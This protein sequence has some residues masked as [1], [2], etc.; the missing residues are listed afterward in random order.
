MSASADCATVIVDQLLG[1]GVTEAVLAPGSRSAPLAYALLAAER[2]GRL[3]LH[4]RIDE[5]SAGFLALGLAK[6]S[7]C[8][9][10][11]V[12]TSGTAVAN[13][14]P[15]VLEA[16]HSSVPLLVISADR[17]S[18][19]IGTG[20]NQTTQQRGLFAPHVRAEAQLDADAG[21]E[22]S[23][24][25]AAWRHQLARLVSAATG[26][27][28][29]TP[30]P[31]HLNVAFAEPLLPDGTTPAL[32]PPVRIESWPGRPD[33]VPLP[34]GPTTVI[35]AGDA[36][37]EVGAAASTLAGEAGLPL[38][39]EPSSNARG[40]AEAITGYRL[41]LGSSLA[42]EIERVVVFGHP[43]LSRPV[44]RLLGRDDIELIVVADGAEWGD[45]ATNAARVVDTLVVAGRHAPEWLD[46]WRRADVRL[47]PRIEGL[48][49]RPAGSGR[50]SGP[51]LAQTVWQSLGRGDVLVAGSSNPIRDLDLA[52]ARAD[53]PSVYANRGLAGIDGTVSTAVGIALACRRP[54]HLLVGDLTF[55]HDSN[56]LILG[57]SEPRPDLRI[58]VADDDGG[59]IFA[60]LEQGAPQRHD[61]FERLFGTAHGVDLTALT[62]A[63]GLDSRRIDDPAALTE[64][65]V[66]RPSGL[67]V[68]AVPVDRTERRSLDE[69]L[70]AAGTEIGDEF[71]TRR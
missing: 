11:V 2:A 57:R 17:P 64:L 69:A 32:P 53:A 59:S 20:A 16:W 4:V 8:P 25:A 39:A 14:H 49:G 29:N 67:E 40:A 13:L 41:L 61:D 37:P 70:R 62:E 42:A 44:Q 50:M 12:T 28:T 19:M 54:T 24:R 6:A 30:G 65:L 34:P 7:Q 18:S 56:G 9:V 36:S 45:P 3:R 46:R 22:E 26:G 66:R 5:R 38:F 15:A 1:L 43:T 60:T 23:S 63:T 27:R 55:L 58:V 35:V 68:V 21:G 48:I 51:L 52:G 10:P 71:A 47:R 33:P 31:V